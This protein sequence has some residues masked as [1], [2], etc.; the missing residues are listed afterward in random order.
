MLEDE[1]ED[2]QDGAEAMQQLMQQ[3]AARR[4]E[5]EVEELYAVQGLLDD[6]Y[7]RVS[8]D[9]EQ[10][11][12]QREQEE[13]EEEERK[14][15]RRRKD[16]RELRYKG[17]TWSREQ[18]VC[19][20]WLT[21]REEKLQ[22]P[23]DSK[24]RD[25]EDEAMPAA[26]ELQ[27]EAELMVVEK[28]EAGEDSAA[29]VRYLQFV[30]EGLVR[31]RVRTLKPQHRQQKRQKRRRQKAE[32]QQQQ[33][34]QAMRGLRDRGDQR[35]FIVLDE[36]D[37][38]DF[39][40]SEA[41]EEE[42]KE[43]QR[44]DEEEKEETA[45]HEEERYDWT[46]SVVSAVLPLTAPVLLHP[47]SVILTHRPDNGIDSA[48]LSAI[49]SLYLKGLL[50]LRCQ[51]EAQGRWYR[52]WLSITPRAMQ[53]AVRGRE[54]V[55]AMIDVMRWACDCPQLQQETTAST[56]SDDAAN[57]EFDPRDLYAAALPPKQTVQQPL[58]TDAVDDCEEAEPAEAEEK[59]SEPQAVA[60]DSD[61]NGQAAAA[62]SNSPLLSQ[63]SLSA[64]G[65]L[66]TLRPYQLEAAQWMLQRETIGS[67]SPSSYLPELSVF[68][69]RCCL[70]SPCPWSRVSA[71]WLDVVRGVVSL[72]P[73]RSE[74]L[75]EV[76]GGLLCDE[77][78]LGKTVM[79]IAL[80]LA[81][82]R[83]DDTA[84]AAAA[85]HL[86]V[87]P[88]QDREAE[89]RQREEQTRREASVNMQ[90]ERQRV[91]AAEESKSGPEQ[92]EEL[93]QPEGMRTPQQQQEEEQQ[94]Q[95]RQQ[96]REEAGPVQ[97]P[98]VNALGW[99]EEDGRFV[100]RVRLRRA[101]QPAAAASP[102]SLDTQQSDD[103]DAGEAEFQP[104][105]EAEAAASLL[106]SSSS[107][108]AS[109]SGPDGGED[110][111]ACFCGSSSPSSRQAFVCCDVCSRWQHCL[112]VSYFPTGCSLSERYVCPACSAAAPP[113]PVKATLV[114]C[115]DVILAQWKEELERHCQPGRLRLLLY[116]GVRGRGSDG[117]AASEAERTTG[118]RDSGRK[119]KRTEPD[120]ADEQQQ[121]ERKEGPSLPQASHDAAMA[122]SDDAAAAFSTP[123]SKLQRRAQRGSPG[124]SSSSSPAGSSHPASYPIVRPCQLEE[125][126]VILTSYSVL[127][128]ELYHAPAE[129]GSG[130]VGRSLRRSKRYGVL[131]SPL[132]GCLYWRVVL[133]ESQMM[134]E[135]TAKCAEMCLRL[136]AVHRWGVSGTAISKGLDDLYGLLLF[137]QLQ[138][139]CDRA[140]WRHCL[141][142]PYQRGDARAREK[143]HRIVAR[144]MWRNSKQSVSQQLALPGLTSRT[145]RLHFTPVERYYYNRREA[146][147]QQAN[148]Q[149]KARA[150]SSSLTAAQHQSLLHSLLRLRQACDHHQLGQS[151]G[152]IS[153]QKHTLS[154]REMTQQLWAE[155]RVKGE[156]QQRSMIF[157]LHG[158]AGLRMIRGE[159]AEAMQLYRDVLGLRLAMHHS[160]EQ[161]W[162]REVE[163]ERGRGGQ[164]P[165]QMDMLQE[166]HALSNLAEAAGRAFAVAEPAAPD[167]PA[168]LPLATGSLSAA[169]SVPTS[170]SSSSSSTPLSSSTSV[171]SSACSS[172]SASSPPATVSPAVAALVS[173]R[174]DFLRCRVE[175]LKHKHLDKSTAVFL[176]TR[177]KWQ[178]ATAETQQLQTELAASAGAD[179]Y[180]E[181]IS[182]VSSS[183][184]AADLADALIRRV[185]AELADSNNGRRQQG[186]ETA[187]IVD[188]FRDLSGLRI[189][190]VNH[191]DALQTARR[192]VL[193]K[194]G[195]MVAEQPPSAAA[196]ALSAGC[197]RCRPEGRSSACNHCKVEV[198]I[199]QWEKA[200]YRFVAEQSL[201]FVFGANEVGKEGLIL[202]GS[203]RK[204]QRHLTDAL[205]APAAA[206]DEDE[207]KE[208]ET[209]LKIPHEVELVLRVVHSFLSQHSREL[210]ADDDGDESRLQSLLAAGSL[211]LQSLAAEKK[212]CR[213]TRTLSSHHRDEL[214]A[215]DEI[216][217]SCTRMQLKPAS[218]GKKQGDGWAEADRQQQQP[219]SAVSRRVAQQQQRVRE[220]GERR[221]ARLGLVSEHELPG[222]LSLYERDRLSAA[223]GLRDAL[224]KMQFLLSQMQGEDAGP[225]PDLC[226]IC[227]DRDLRQEEEVVV[228]AACG[229][230]YC[231]RCIL[232]LLEIL[233]QQRAQF[234]TCGVCRTKQSKKSLSYV[235]NSSREA[236][237]GS[238]S[239]LQLQ[240]LGDE[241][242]GVG[243]RVELQSSSS[244]SS[245]PLLNSLSAG[246]P[247]AV[248]GSWSTKVG[249]VVGLVLGIV[250]S[251]P[252][253]KLLLF[254]E[255]KD[256][257]HIL[258]R[259]LKL[260]AVPTLSLI[261]RPSYAA[262]LRLFHQSA[263]HRVLLL[264]LKGSA[265]GLNLTA[266]S[267]VIFA[268]PSLSVAREEQAVG[269]VWRLGQQR[270]CE[271][272]RM[273]VSASVEER[274]QWRNGKGGSGWTVG[275]GSGEGRRRRR[276]GRE[277][278]EEDVREDEIDALL[279]A[280]TEAAGAA[281]AP[282]SQRADRPRQHR[283]E[284]DVTGDDEQKA[285][286][287]Q[288]P[289][290]RQEEAQQEAERRRL[291]ADDSWWQ[292]V[293]SCPELGGRLPRLAVL[294]RLQRLR[295]L[296]RG[297]D[298]SRS[299][300]GA[301]R[302]QHSGGAA[303]ARLVVHHGREVYDSIAQQI[304]QL[305]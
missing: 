88:Q 162:R 6:F 234:I 160:D 269:R 195:G 61:V 179:W 143:L 217:M 59:Y 117:R 83:G 230:R 32:Q 113:V 91:I 11:E 71:V 165:I 16:R 76:R 48:T 180:S 159:W 107:P 36:S 213:V 120:P 26:D 182:L 65:L 8:S 87:F 147:C 75:T 255:W 68:W 286:M 18:C 31:R 299:G 38:S 220:E 246:V 268:E 215:Y 282:A 122:D 56:G 77:M 260:N 108:S 138:P 84:A 285:D 116:S 175:L 256:M 73:Q 257:L 295:A 19:I 174:I 300:T 118:H 57:D 227:L 145:H 90:P 5:R 74:Q 111:V 266:A 10:Q 232:K 190:V 139:Y 34:A 280:D 237:S 79:C 41:E 176:S 163:E 288:Q 131:P 144:V 22:R 238:S 64:L 289:Q 94:E 183:A 303:D 60:I 272:H 50:S 208:A 25:E 46:E 271:V 275:G 254:S 261:S 161:A 209:Q 253:A 243:R 150:T 128:S 305:T 137:L 194:L 140:Y 231:T 66:P 249:A 149:C 170:P 287:T 204:A 164:R 262:T 130:A 221:N 80:F 166:I 223:A 222:L 193:D 198:L 284:V 106:S 142:L 224:S 54:E 258:A 27:Q 293:V 200:L 192:R 20:G 270:D 207:E 67:V 169:S 177:S 2:E 154:M 63:A 191:L 3:E 226:P 219:S 101:E 23:E 110:V 168:A 37:D 12:R 112:C 189:L 72:N 51:Y 294:V 210:A 278:L 259:A 225:Q 235:A 29:V 151:T 201:G 105:G 86:T 196:I 141:A 13:Q 206:A 78:G 185:K 17:E 248:R 125:Y 43:I 265:Q 283:E 124:S 47:L 158:T 188:A 96:R 233:Q 251:S 297:K 211:H 240:G 14:R 216:S 103:S 119:R 281:A 30:R 263:S 136:P 274:I 49:V 304:D 279:A 82:R 21:V 100:I 44:E 242:G 205:L 148:A 115:P 102:H 212:E 123:P 199:R 134:G 276:Q 239:A 69:R 93:K 202:E 53:D 1:E 132:L 7:S 167:S 40:L 121:E 156:E 85:P 135:G 296:D 114:C 252:R 187:S 171:S 236:G 55:R 33:V 292:T 264:P 173:S 214:S 229:H 184:S 291:L 35:E 273:I 155:A 301:S 39:R 153:L 45:A 42:K 126:D 218:P 203:T 186:E 267:H 244:S 290:Q 302:V 95:S 152:F 109:A 133:D 98:A 197:S 24:E 52:L 129:P 250:A 178:A 146:E 277:Q 298:E 4:E 89:Q 241:L 127:S 247:A 99:E 62:V 97:R 157:A 28:L 81:H 104:G 245:S 181:A 15:K 172:A 70:F 9:D 58:R 92:T 228:L